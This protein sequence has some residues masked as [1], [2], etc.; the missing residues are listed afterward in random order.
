MKNVGERLGTDG[1][2]AAVNIL[3]HEWGHAMQQVL[4]ISHSAT[5]PHE[6]QADCFAGAFANHAYQ[7]GYIE[8]GDIEEAQMGMAQVGD[9][10]NSHG[11]PKERLDAFSKG[12]ES[13]VGVCRY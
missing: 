13:G 2:M 11:T 8:E 5:K 10:R 4:G 1:D 7:Q 3:A 6:L 12:Y 9:A